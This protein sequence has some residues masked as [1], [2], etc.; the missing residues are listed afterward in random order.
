MKKQLKDGTTVKITRAGRLYVDGVLV[1]T[2]SDGRPICDRITP[3]H[4]PPNSVGEEIVQIARVWA[5]KHYRMVQ[6]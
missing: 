4:L 2:L 3:I 6:N 5:A 1:H